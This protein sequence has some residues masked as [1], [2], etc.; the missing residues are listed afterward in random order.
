MAAHS[1]HGTDAVYNAGAGTR[2]FERRDFATP[3]LMFPA[4]P[5]SALLPA[6]ERVL[7]VWT[8]DGGARAYPLSALAKLDGA[9]ADRLQ[10]KSVSIHY[11]REAH[12]ARV[13]QADDGVRW[14]Y[15]F[16]FA[17]FAFH[18]KTDVFAAS[19]NQ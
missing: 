2:S 4:R 19:N 9:V 5:T 14:V 3:K 7:G 15:S 18:P 16:W 12:S 8:D 10:G 6:K 13:E 17:W 11:D 1:R